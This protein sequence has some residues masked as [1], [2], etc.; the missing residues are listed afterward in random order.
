MGYSRTRT[1]S[2]P[3]HEVCAW[4]SFRHYQKAVGAFIVFD[5]T[6][7]K[8]FLHVNE[9][10]SAILDK[11]DSNVQIG[12]LGHKIDHLRREVTHE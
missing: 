8:S 10:L 1:V 11:A 7:R 5:V 4:S 12:L 3:H 2:S 6:N 9:W